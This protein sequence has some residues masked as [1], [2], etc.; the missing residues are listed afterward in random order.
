MT[1]PQDRDRDGPSAAERFRRL[2]EERSSRP[3]PAEPDRWSRLRS[4]LWLYL[5]LAVAV[6]VIAFL[7]GI[8]VVQIR[9]RVL[10]QVDPAPGQSLGSDAVPEVA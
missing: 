10:E 3:P 4:S 7:A 5:K 8:L 1:D 6:A 9:A 2:D